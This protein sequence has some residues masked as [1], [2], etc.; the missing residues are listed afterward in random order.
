M[1]PLTKNQAKVYEYIRNCIV[2]KRYSP[3]KT[4]I[5]KEF[6]YRS[7]NSAGQ[8]INILKRKGWVLRNGEGLLQ[9]GRDWDYW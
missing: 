9:L 8:F 7:P 3:S 1:Q 6:G 2:N 4:E 5:S